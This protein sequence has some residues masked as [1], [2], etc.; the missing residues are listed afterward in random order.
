MG[1]Q[2]DCLGILMIKICEKQK[3]SWFEEKTML[4]ENWVTW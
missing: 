1:M 4:E 3:M 2:V